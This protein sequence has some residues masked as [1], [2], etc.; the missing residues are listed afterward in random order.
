MTSS[1]CAQGNRM[2]ELTDY[3]IQRSPQELLP[4]SRLVVVD[5]SVREELTCAICLGLLC[6]TVATRCLHRF[7]EECIT[8]SL[9]RCNKYCPTCRRKIPSKR[10]LRRDHRMDALIAVLY[11]NGD[12]EE[13]E[14]SRAAAPRESWSSQPLQAALQ[15]MP[16]R[17]GEQHALQ[18]PPYQ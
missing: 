1:N 16:R 3:E 18:G 5:E 13:D 15:G 14:T 7:C 11:P 10:S 8:T 17:G 9:R 4:E 2:W 6:N 12:D